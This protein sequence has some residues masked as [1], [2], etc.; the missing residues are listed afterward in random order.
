MIV[1]LAVLLGVAAAL[2]WGSAKTR[3][4]MSWLLLAIGFSVFAI[5]LQHAGPYAM[6]SQGNLRAGLLALLLGAA[7]VRPW[8][9][10]DLRGRILTGVVLA[11]SPVVLFFALYATLAELEE[12]VVLRAESEAGKTADL[13]L[14]IVDHEGAEW[15]TMGREKADTHGLTRT[16][17]ELLRQGELRCVEAVRF[18][19]RATVNKAHALRHEKYTIQRLATQIGIFG[20]SAAENVIAVR[21]LP[22]AGG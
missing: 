6:P 20:A 1:M 8:F 18:E 15:V 17:A 10:A 16:R 22:C 9:G 19:D 13:R 11:I 12:V 3:A 7:L 5:R 4:P 14:W 21:L 2:V